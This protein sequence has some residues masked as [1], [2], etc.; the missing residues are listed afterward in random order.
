MQFARDSSG[1]GC[2]IYLSTQSDLCYKHQTM[3]SVR[4]LD[5]QKM[6]PH[7]TPAASLPPN[8]ATSHV[9]DQ[10]AGNAAKPRPDASMFCPNCSTELHPHRCKAVCKNCGFYLSCSDP[11]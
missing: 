7:K 1:A 6:D 9:A 5:L 3:T 2:N 8:L 11:W 4:P 10:V